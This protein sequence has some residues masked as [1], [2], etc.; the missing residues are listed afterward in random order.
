MEQYPEADRQRLR[1]LAR[2]ASKEKAGNKPPKSSREIF[3][4]L[5]EAML[6]KQEI[7]EESEDDLD[8]AE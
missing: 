5:K 2:Q 7:E 4:L 8:S 6:A 3:Q 1:L